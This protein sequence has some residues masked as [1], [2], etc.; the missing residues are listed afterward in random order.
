MAKHRKIAI[1]VT[2]ATL[3]TLSIGASAAGRGAVKLDNSFSFRLNGYGGTAY[4][5]A[6]TKTNSNSFAEYVASGGSV[7]DNAFITIFVTSEK[8]LSSQVS[9]SDKITVINGKAINS[10]NYDSPAPGY[11]TSNYLCAL[12]SYYGASVSGTW[13][14]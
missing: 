11:G 2:V 6:A 8:N 10:L 9:E 13:N 7:D 3:A 14:P 12:G 4:S 5:S 1:A